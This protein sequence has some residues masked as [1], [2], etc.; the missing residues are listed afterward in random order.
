MATTLT[1]QQQLTLSHGIGGSSIANILGL[2]YGSPLDEY[3]KILHPE[4]RVDLSDNPH[5]QAGIYL[6]PTIRQMAIDVLKLPVRQ[7]NITK[8]HPQFC[9]MRA[10]IDGKIQ[11]F[12]EGIEFKNRGYFQGSRYGEQGTDEVLDSELLQ[13]LWYLMI[14][15]WQRWHL[16]V[17]IGGY[18][19]RHFII[20]R[21]EALIAEITT[22]ARHFWEE[23]VLKQIPPDPINNSDLKQLYPK[24][25]G[26]SIEAPANIIDLVEELQ[27]AKLVAA[28][29][30][31]RVEVLDIQLKNFIGS[32]SVL[33]DPSGKPLATWKSQTTSRIDTSRLKVEQPA[34]AKEYTKSTETRVL[35]IK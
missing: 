26:Q 2:G 11:G 4:T 8:F 35:R 27:A 1:P 19:L 6:E 9:Y 3:T 12:D 32:N 34:I 21:D 18:D 15:G 23:H 7:C 33:T 28:E 10:N 22:K 29:E 24:D 17:L 16:V 31:V 14:T 20:N 5:V 13:C 30:A 25:T